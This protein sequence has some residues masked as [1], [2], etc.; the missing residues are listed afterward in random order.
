[1]KYKNITRKKGDDGTTDLCL[2]GRVSK[3][4]PRIKAVGKIDTLHAAMGLCHKYIKGSEIYNDFI[5]IQRNLTLLMGELCCEDFLNYYKNY[6][7]I[8]TTHLDGLDIILDGVAE[9]LDNSNLK[10]EGWSYYGEEGSC[11]AQL[12]FAGTLCRECEIQIL[13]LKEDG[14]EV[15]DLILAYMNRLS[16]VL[17][18]YARKFEERRNA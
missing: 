8:G 17:Y 16:K 11:S 1:M 3:T 5:S 9:E 6:G 18:L 2:G 12:D 14:F 7:G 15:R 10:Q 4:D 13:E